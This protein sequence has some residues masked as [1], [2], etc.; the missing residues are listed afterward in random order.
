MRKIA[1]VVL[2]ICVLVVLAIALIPRFI[3]FNNYRG[4]IQTELQN[5]L[6]RPV[7]LGNIRASLL[8]PSLVVKNVVIGEDPRFGSGDFAKARELDVRVGL[9]PLLTKKIDVKSLELV[10]PDIQL[11]RNANGQWNYSTLGE[12]PAPS[13]TSPAPP[14]TSKPSGVISPPATQP[15]SET[16][17]SS[18]VSLNHLVITNGR[19]HLIDQQTGTQKTFENIDLTLSNFAPG[20]A[21]DVSGAVH[22]AGKG[23]QAI[24]VNGTAGPMIAGKTMF[25]FN[26]TVDLKDISLADLQKVGNISA[27][28][29]YNGVASG[30]V[31]AKSADGVL[32]ADGSIT[33]QNPQIKGSSLGFPISADFK[34]EDHLDSGVL[35]IQNGVVK[36]GPTPFSFGGTVNFS[37]KPEQVDLHVATEGASLAEIARLAAVTGVAFNP[38]TN[39]NG[40]LNADITARGAVNNPALNGSLVASGVEITGGQIKQSVTIPEIELSLS[41]TQISSNPFLARTGGTQLHTQFALTSYISNSPSLRVFIETNNAQISEL[42]AMA[43]AYGI[44]AVQGVSGSGVITLNVNTSGPLKNA[45][46]MIFNGTGSVQNATLHMPALTQPLGVRN[47]NIRFSQN[48]VTLDNLAASLGPTNATGHLSL[49]NFANPQVQFALNMDKLDLAAMQ[50]IIA[51]PG[52]PMKA[53]AFH[54][55]PR[56]NA[57]TTT[58]PSL[59]TKAVGQGT[60]S[61]GVL[62]YNELVLDNVKSNVTLNQGIIQLAPLTSTLYGGQQSGQITLDTRVTPAAVTVASRLQKVDANKLLSAVTSIKNTLYGLLAAN[63]NASFRAVGGNNFA[64]TLDGKLSLDL[65]NG[66]IAGVDLLNQ[67][68]HI[69]RF[70]NASSAIPAKP[71]TDLAKLTGTFVVTNGIAQT[72]DLR[73]AIPGAN[74]AANGTAN[75]V[76]NAVNMHVTAVLSKALSQQ[77]GGSSIGGF[78]QTALANNNGELVIPVIVTGT[79]DHPQFAPDVQ[80]IAQM[81]LQNLVPSFGNPGNLTSGI[82]GAVLGGKK[83]QSQGWGGI[84]GAITGQQPPTNEQGQQQPSAVGE[85]QQQKQAQPA[86]PLGDLLN[87]VLQGKKK[88]QPQ[89]PQ[90]QSPPPQ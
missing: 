42:L 49:R 81:K 36:L 43:N 10:D 18:N 90:Q 72:N 35:Q 82:L 57:A 52:A 21:F 56:A 41:P 54:L 47:A 19:V 60:V 66:R 39:L 31:Q 64:Q 30:S 24:K 16:S 68:S 6:G 80:Q 87:Q 23:N 9:I 12:A 51:T 50:Q 63:T 38:G 28:Q 69:G 74:L 59:L 70:L 20:K 11:I 8:P 3:N 53:A 1:I 2:I 15:P 85:N 4:Q 84:V 22:I 29:G 65:S 37:L 88:K 13:Q 7:S 17:T 44:S 26:G 76:N 46:A 62:T 78:M 67:L 77:V 79:L 71:F 75:L 34:I 32:H 89:Q 61:V 86:N 25:P 58:Q 40:N 14:Q 55:V 48:S 33:I 73:A 5:R 45:S 27:L 83:A